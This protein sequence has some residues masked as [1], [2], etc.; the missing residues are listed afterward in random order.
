[1]SYDIFIDCPQC[2]HTIKASSDLV[3]VVVDCPDCDYQ[4]KLPDIREGTNPRLRKSKA[5]LPPAGTQD[6][7]SNIDELSHLEDQM[8]SLLRRQRDQLNQMNLLSS[9]CSLIQKQLEFLTGGKAR[10]DRDQIAPGYI[11]EQA[12]H[13]A[14]TW[15]RLSKISG[16]TSVV[17]MVGVGLWIYCSR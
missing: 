11:L 17:V 5:K 14:S 12:S 1:M 13:R 2:K 4:F 15:I 16:W 10:V 8:R 7:E 6:S 9:N 3:G